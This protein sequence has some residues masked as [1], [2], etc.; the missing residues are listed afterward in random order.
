MS[1]IKSRWPFF[2]WLRFHR[3]CENYCVMDST[4][5]DMKHLQYIVIFSIVINKCRLRTC[6]SFTNLRCHDDFYPISQYYILLWD[7]LIWSDRHSALSHT[8]VHLLPF[9]TLDKCRQWTRTSTQYLLFIPKGHLNND[10]Y[11]LYSEKKDGVVFLCMHTKKS[12]N[13]LTILCRL[14]FNQ[15]LDRNIKHWLIDCGRCSSKFSHISFH[16]RLKSK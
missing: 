13:F 2:L 4:M 9:E 7:P 1:T 3:C 8:P 10:F 14:R 15:T 11:R 6:F 12:E 16:L 5:N